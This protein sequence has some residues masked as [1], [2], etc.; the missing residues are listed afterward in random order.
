MTERLHQAGDTG[1]LNGIAGR[2]A[3]ATCKDNSTK[4]DSIIKEEDEFYHMERS[5]TTL[6]IVPK[7]WLSSHTV[8]TAGPQIW[9]DI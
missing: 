8:T 1:V 6:P 7:V 3:R 9:S 4:I 5:V 2:S